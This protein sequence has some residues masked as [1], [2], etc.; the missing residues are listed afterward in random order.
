LTLAELANAIA[1]GDLPTVSLLRNAKVLAAELNQRETASWIDAE[2]EGEF[3]LGNVPAY[4]YIPV[5]LVQRVPGINGA[6]V[7]REPGWLVE[8]TNQPRPL[9][10]PVAELEAN[11]KRPEEYIFVEL[12]PGMLDQLIELGSGTREMWHRTSPRLFANIVDAV[13]NRLLTWTLELRSLDV[14]GHD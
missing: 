9:I 13:K 7:V 3:E 14:R 8:I 1:G 10:N 12:S 11:A 4:R 5:Q 2:L 6:Q